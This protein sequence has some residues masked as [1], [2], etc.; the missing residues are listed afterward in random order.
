[1]LHQ[2]NNNNY[3]NLQDDAGQ[4]N[5][6]SCNGNLNNEAKMMHHRSSTSSLV[7]LGNRNA[8]NNYQFHLIY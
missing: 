3:I 4:F 6:A 1:M 5:S 2:N 7:G 8:T